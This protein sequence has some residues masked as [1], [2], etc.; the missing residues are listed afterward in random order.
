M[1]FGV[2]FM[3]QEQGEAYLA[4]QPGEGVDK[5]EWTYPFMPPFVGTEDE[6]AALAAYVAELPAASAAAAA[7]GGE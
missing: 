3:M 2:L 1:V 6:M 4:V 5:R 7:E